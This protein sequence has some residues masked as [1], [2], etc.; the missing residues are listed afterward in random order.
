MW[1]TLF[2]VVSPTNCLFSHDS[3]FLTLLSLHIWSYHNNNQCIKWGNI[4]IPESVW[5]VHTSA[6]L[7]VLMCFVVVV[8]CLSFLVAVHSCASHHHRCEHAYNGQLI[9]KEDES[10]Q[11]LWTRC[12]SL[13]LCYC[14]VC[15]CVM[16]LACCHL[17]D[18]L[19]VVNATNGRKC[20]ISMEVSALIASGSKNNSSTIHHYHHLLLPLPLHLHHCSI[21]QT[22]ALI[23]SHR[24]NENI[25]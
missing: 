3:T 10:N 22:A 20:G 7:F 19:C 14:C 23:H 17:Y 13:T 16:L 18:S 15:C 1:Y 8:I 11:T 25:S 6:S 4:T 21:D 12:S 24:V 9:T 2:F 5:D